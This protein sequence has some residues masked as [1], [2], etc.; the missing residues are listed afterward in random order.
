[1]TPAIKL[2]KCQTVL[3]CLGPKGPPSVGIGL[4]M[5]YNYLATM[6]R[7]VAIDNSLRSSYTKD[8]EAIFVIKIKLTLVTDKNY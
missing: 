8:F 5:M 3:G 1:M 7:F 2:W 4:R 6:K